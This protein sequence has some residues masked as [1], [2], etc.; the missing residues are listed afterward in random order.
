[1]SI[2]DIHARTI[3]YLIKRKRC[4]CGN[5]IEFSSPE[6]LELNKVLDY[7]PPKSIGTL[8]GQFVRE[9]ELKIESSTDTFDRIETQYGDVRGFD[10][11]RSDIL[12]DIDTIDK[13]LEGMMF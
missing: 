5:P 2:P 4:I 7:I 9:C 6:Y 8:I 3:E 11:D 1:M 13:R 12:S 10:V